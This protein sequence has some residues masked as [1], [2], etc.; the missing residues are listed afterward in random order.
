M[1]MLGEYKA[2]VKDI[3]GKITGSDAMEAREVLREIYGTLRVTP[4]IE[5]VKNTL[6]RDSSGS[7][8]AC[9]RSIG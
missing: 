9:S 7:P 6:L 3:R 1:Q 2:P 8:D 4:T 5:N